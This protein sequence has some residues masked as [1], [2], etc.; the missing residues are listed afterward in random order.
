MNANTPTAL[1]V[2]YVH[3]YLHN[4]N[5]ILDYTREQF[6]RKDFHVAS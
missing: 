3:I 1:T 4:N 6:V 5:H 2:A